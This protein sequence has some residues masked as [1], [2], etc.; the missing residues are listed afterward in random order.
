MPNA[1]NAAEP[2][3]HHYVPAMYLRGFAGTKGQLFAINRAED[4]W[5]R[6]SPDNVA[7]KKHFNRIE[8]PRMDP[9]ALEKALSEFEG[10]VAPAL[11]RIK[12]AKS[13]SVEADRSLLVNFVAA[14]ALRN[15]RRRD[16]LGKIISLEKRRSFFDRFGT[17]D[18]IEAQV[19]DMKSKGLLDDQTAL[20]FR[21]TVAGVK[22]EDFKATKE[23]IIVAEIDH[24][25]LLTER[26][27]H[28]KWQ[29][30][31]AADDTGG[32][33]TTDDPVCLRWSDGHPHGGMS[34]GFALAG[35]EVIFPLSTNIALGGDVRRRRERRQVRHGHSRTAEQPDHQQRR[36][37]GLC[38]RPHVQIQA[39]DAGRV[40]ERRH[41][42]PGQGLHRRGRKTL[43]TPGRFSHATSS[44]R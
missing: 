28:R 17:K 38:A 25:D 9:N 37:S 40:G 2:K 32:F 29:M 43:M 31:V 30:L 8:V 23:E 15:P 16:D 7:K 33:V 11:E 13:L 34:P 12:D 44:R 22:V 3:G 39:P 41:P 4:K 6:T 27:W 42:A 36:E 21:E 18:K 26:L 19:H 10:E 24:H 1:V 35:T 5:F 14:I 20:S